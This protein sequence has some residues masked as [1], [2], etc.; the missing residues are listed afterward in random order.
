[1]KRKI[2][3]MIGILIGVMLLSGCGTKFPEL[4][5]EQNQQVAEYAV[6]LLMKYDEKHESRLLNEAQLEKELSRLKTLAERKAQ[7]VEADQVRKQAK[8]EEQR[9]KEEALE[10]TPV[11]NA[12]E[13]AGGSQSAAMYMEDFFGLEGVQIRYAGYAVEET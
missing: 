7:L 9:Q 8:E 3:G 13:T 2:N 12:S 4:S 6:G 1:M 10:N 11:A 5:E